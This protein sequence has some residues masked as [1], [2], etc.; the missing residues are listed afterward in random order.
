MG[1]SIIFETK[2]VTL[3]DGR[4]IHFDRSGCNNDDAGRSRSE[5]SG[6]VYTREQFIEYAERFKKESKPYKES[7]RF[8]LK[9]GSRYAT[10][11]DYGEHLLR[12]LNR[13]ERYE[14]FVRSR[15]CWADIIT[16]IEV[17]SPEYKQ[18]TLE[19]FEKVFYNLLYSGSRLSYRRMREPLDI[20][21]EKAVVTALES[22]KTMEFYIGKKRTA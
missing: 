11:Y 17:L 3:S 4:I 9:I 8:E 12:M 18:M 2:I 6:K 5:F 15:G 16:G 14:E 22:G 13:A 19:E 21:D 1:Y 20:K 10:A 7:D